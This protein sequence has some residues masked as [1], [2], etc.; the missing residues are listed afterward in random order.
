MFSFN[1]TMLSERLIE[2]YNG[3]KIRSHMEP[4][5]KSFV[6]CRLAASGDVA[7]MS[8]GAYEALHT[9]LFREG[10]GSH[11]GGA[12]LRSVVT[13]R[14]MVEGGALPATTSF[15]LDFLSLSNVCV[16]SAAPGQWDTSSASTV[17]LL[18]AAENRVQR[19]WTLSDAWRFV[20]DP[21]LTLKRVL[22]SDLWSAAVAVIA[23]AAEC[24]ARAVATPD[25]LFFNCYCGS[26]DVIDAAS[27]AKTLLARHEPPT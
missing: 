26:V 20:G 1:A 23:E 12:A 14:L 17:R 27:I 3:R 22:D 21:G 7:P 2:T 16:P 8:R 11:T 18:M 25:A 10:D 19:M 4:I 6:R 24:D 15:A 13:A 5:A 9:V